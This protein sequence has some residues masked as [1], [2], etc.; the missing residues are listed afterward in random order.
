MLLHS[1]ILM[2]LDFIT[3]AHIWT[4]FDN[5]VLKFFTNFVLVLGL[6]ITVLKSLVQ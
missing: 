6:H 2:G 3:S 5:F 1:S 4:S